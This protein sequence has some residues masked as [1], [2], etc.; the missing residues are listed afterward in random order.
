MRSK[1]IM[2]FAILEDIKPLFQEIEH[3]INISYHLAGLH[4]Q[5][6][7]FFT[8]TILGIPNLGFVSFGDWNKVDRYLVLIEEESL[9]IRE[10]VQR[11]GT[12]KFAIDQMNNPK[13]IEL[14]I[15]GIYLHKEKVIV[16]GR[17]STIS[18]DNDSEKLFKLFSSKIKRYFR[19]IDTFYVGPMAELKLKEGWRLVTNEGSPR[20]YDLVLK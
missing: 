17:V 13:S 16:A 3:S 5:S 6:K 9:N 8:N 15:G 18:E 10:V 2:F 11:E 4:D 1:Q 20:D 14:K 12:T 7:V 19:K